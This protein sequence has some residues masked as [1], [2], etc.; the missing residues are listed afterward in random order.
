MFDRIYNLYADL[1]S[2]FISVLDSQ[3]DITD[4]KLVDSFFMATN[5]DE[6]AL[7]CFLRN[8]IEKKKSE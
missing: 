5:P 3:T 7:Y 8:M 2:Y 6:Y 1:E 4:D